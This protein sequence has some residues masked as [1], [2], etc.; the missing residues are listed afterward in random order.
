MQVAPYNAPARAPFSGNEDLG[1]AAT[2]SGKLQWPPC[3]EG[4]KRRGEARCVFGQRD[5]TKLH[6]DACWAEKTSRGRGAEGPV[7]SLV[8]HLFIQP[9]KGSA[10]KGRRILSLFKIIAH[11][12]HG[13]ATCYLSLQESQCGL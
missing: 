3:L 1:A 11:A 9:T 5:R 7:D 13:H 4:A 10:G 8:A 2:G 12:R 6:C